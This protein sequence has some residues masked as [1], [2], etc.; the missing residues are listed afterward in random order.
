[1]KKSFRTIISFL[2]VAVLILSFSSCS[3]FESMRN[4]ANNKPEIFDTPEEAAVIDEFNKLLDASVN[5]AV[6]ITESVS[7]SAGRPE[8][9]NA[10]GEEAG[11]LDAAANQLKSFIMSGNPGGTSEEITGTADTLLKDIDASKVVELRFERNIA[12]ENETDDKGNEKTEVVTNESGAEEEVVVTRQY[13]SDNTLH[14]TFSYYESVPA[15]EAA[16]LEET[17]AEET[18]APEAEDIYAEDIYAEDIY[19]EEVVEETE[20][21]TTEEATTEEATTEEATT[22]EAAAEE[23]T[24]EESEETTEE[25]TTVIYADDSVIEAVFG[26]AKSKEDV[27]KNFECISEYIT[28]SDY[29]TENRECRISSD[30][31]LGEGNLS[32]V[33]FEQNMR[34]TVKAQGTGALAEYGD[35]EIV[36]DLTKTTTYDFTYETVEEGAEDTDTTEAAQDDTTE[37]QSASEEESVSEALSEEATTLSSDEQE[38]TEAE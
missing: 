1:M 25:E 24:A 7:Y 20:E 10:E 15:A 3:I 30:A 38:I 14:I 21:E 31:D 37:A 32:F 36:F 6:K 33:R 17:T 29:T 11:I 5:S 22:E 27:L 16:T 13:I 19:A 26:S 8:V 4:A 2:T 18:T 34:V 9:L 23:A 12:T 28:V 35:I